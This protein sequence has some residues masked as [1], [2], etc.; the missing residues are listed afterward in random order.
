MN[1]EP[2]VAPGAGHA[3]PD[4]PAMLQTVTQAVGAALGA[5][6]VEL[7]T[8]TPEQD[9]IA[10]RAFW[11]CEEAGNLGRERVGTVIGLTQSSDLRRL[12]LTGRPAVRRVDDP[13]VPAAERA[14]LKAEGC[15]IRVDYPLILHDR[16]LGILSVADARA[17]R[18]A[19]AA[20]ESRLGRFCHLAASA[21]D[22]VVA[23]ERQEERM[24]RLVALLDPERSVTATL[25][26]REAV[27]RVTADIASVLPGVELEI[28]VYVRRDDGTFGKAVADGAESCA[29]GAGAVWRPD[30]L[31]RQ[32]VDRQRVEQVRPDD[33]TTRLIVPLVVDGSVTGCLDLAGRI[34][35]RFRQDEVELVGLLAGQVA[36]ALRNAR[37]FSV[38][39]NRSATDALTGL[40]S[41]WYFVERLSAEVARASR[42]KA[43]LALMLAE[44]DG[45]ERFCGDGG[46]GLDEIVR[47]TARLVRGCLRD[48][49][50]VACYQGSGRFA[51]M[52]PNTPALGGHAGTVAERVRT[53]LERTALRSDE[54]ARVERC[55]V[56]IA[57]AGFPADAEDADELTALAEAALAA[58]RRAGGNRIVA[59]GEA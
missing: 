49:V 17:D 23:V 34:A 59:A 30:A 26:V 20:D 42:Y 16:I 45:V 56:S 13:E 21:L 37:V 15:R 22:A 43:P 8:F 12:V 11:A 27:D 51:V 10:C 58:A 35:R 5:W 31:A 41:S 48:K 14:V 3:A 54:S 25:R 55:T 52:L 53:R 38:L 24:R 29:D 57:V 6:W 4:L 9:T 18:L 46:L 40:Y 19:S 1:L 32:A 44:L 50:D 39:E 47:A 2:S 7:W 33:G 36:V 28:E